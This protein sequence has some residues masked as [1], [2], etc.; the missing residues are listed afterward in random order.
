MKEVYQYCNRCKTETVQII[1]VI[2]EKQV[3]FDCINKHQ[4]SY[5]LEKIEKVEVRFNRL[6]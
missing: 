4:G 2:T 1:K 5:K 3:V 6:G